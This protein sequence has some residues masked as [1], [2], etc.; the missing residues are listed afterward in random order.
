MPAVTPSSPDADCGLSR[1]RGEPS[2]HALTHTQPVL[3]GRADPEAGSRSRTLGP[4]HPRER[5]RKHRAGRA[6]SAP[7]RQEGPSSLPGS[8]PRL[9][10]LQRSREEPASAHLLPLRSPAL[11]CPPLPCQDSPLPPSPAPLAPLLQPTFGPVTAPSLSSPAPW[12]LPANS[13][14]STRTPSPRP[15][16]P[17]PPHCPRHPHR[18]LPQTASLSLDQ[19]HHHRHGRQP[20]ECHH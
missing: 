14:T 3:P 6:G 8:P 12:P 13:S 1:G 2:H 7:E 19:Q 10:G 15:S 11:P 18:H 4:R 20:H 9:L 5:R 17:S 16:A